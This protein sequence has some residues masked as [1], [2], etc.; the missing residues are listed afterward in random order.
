MWT[1]HTKAWLDGG[2]MEDRGA[3]GSQQ[4]L[5]QRLLT[6]GRL[7]SS[8]HRLH[9]E[10]AAC[11]NAQLPRQHHDTRLRATCDHMTTVLEFCS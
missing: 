10:T 2:D 8:L 1:R 7:C 9:N 11:F 4:P 6:E 5:L 3:G